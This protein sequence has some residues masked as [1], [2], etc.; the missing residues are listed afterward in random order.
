MLM[1]DSDE[2]NENYKGTIC[3]HGISVEKKKK[4]TRTTNIFL[5]N[6]SRVFTIFY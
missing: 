2:N 3:F 5:V 1:Y 6:V 4:K